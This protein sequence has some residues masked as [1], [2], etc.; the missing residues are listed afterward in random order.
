MVKTRRPRRDA[1]R[2]A[3]GVAGGRTARPAARFRRRDARAPPDLRA[4]RQPHPGDD[5]ERQPEGRR[6]A[7]DRA[8]DGH[9]LRHQPPAAA[10]GAEG[11]DADGRARKPPGRALHGQ[12]PLAEPA[13][14]AVQRDAL[15]R[16][17]RRA[18]S[19]SRRA[20][21]STSSSCGSAPSTPARSAAAHPEARGRRPRLP[22]GSRGLPPARHR[23]PPGD[24]R[25]RRQ[26]PALGAWRRASTTSGWRSGAWR[27]RCPGVIEKSV[28]AALRGGG[29][30]D[31]AATPRRRSQPI[32]ATSSTSATPRSSPWTRAR[33]EERVPCPNASPF[34]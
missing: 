7:A 2:R 30:D 1:A 13:R 17:L 18:T 9:R 20:P 5:Q 24:Q 11:A 10:R 31:R 28:A 27:A 26:S 33:P 16:R 21:S 4:G 6:Q 29:G 25:R 19:T 14:R 3:E 22:R 34:A 23:V 32:A 12:R 8:A 15:G